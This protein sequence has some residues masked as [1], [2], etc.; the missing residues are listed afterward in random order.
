MKNT[1]FV[2]CRN[3]SLTC[4]N[5]RFYD[6]ANGYCSCNN[7]RCHPYDRACGDYESDD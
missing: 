3:E 4:I 2:C 7:A 6:A 1:N 5:C